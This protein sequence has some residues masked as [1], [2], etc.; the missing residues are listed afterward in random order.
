MFLGNITARCSFFREAHF[1]ELGEFRLR[2]VHRCRY[3]LLEMDHALLCCSFRIRFT[4]LGTRHAVQLPSVSTSCC[5]HRRVV[6]LAD[7]FA[8]A[9]VGNSFGANTLAVWCGDPT[10]NIY[11]F[12]LLLGPSR[13]IVVVSQSHEPSGMRRGMSAEQKGNLPPSGWGH[14]SSERLAPRC[15]STLS[16]AT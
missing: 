7:F 12:V 2:T 6:E 16:S 3:S 9:I 13:G 14:V 15:V 8:I 4:L 5:Q 1:S 10:P 11:L